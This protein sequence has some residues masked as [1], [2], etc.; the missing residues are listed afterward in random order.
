MIHQPNGGSQGQA[1]DVLAESEEVL[2]IR[3]QIGKIY[4][5]RTGQSLDTIAKALDRDR[6]MDAKQAKE[7]GIIDQVASSNK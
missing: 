7:F 3:K 1:S 5:E 6:F 4:A 2:R